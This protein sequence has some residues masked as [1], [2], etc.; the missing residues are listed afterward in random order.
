M[1]AISGLAMLCKYSYVSQRK[2]SETKGWGVFVELSQVRQGFSS[3]LGHVL[4]IR[5]CS[6]ET[7]FWAGKI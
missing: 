1:A 5:F 4:F 3:K 2:K 6:S 7:F